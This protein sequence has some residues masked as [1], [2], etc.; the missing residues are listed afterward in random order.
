MLS[1]SDPP[2]VGLL[3]VPGALLAWVCFVVGLLVFAKRAPLLDDD[4]LSDRCPT[5]EYYDRLR[6]LDYEC[7]QVPTPEHDCPFRR[8][9]R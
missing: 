4:E 1:A 3:L 9:V 5:C 2:V 6:V 7:D 8:S